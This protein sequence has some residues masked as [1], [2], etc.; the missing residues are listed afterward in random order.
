LAL[1]ELVGHHPNAIAAAHLKFFDV[2]GSHPDWPREVVVERLNDWPSA[3]LAVLGKVA[4]HVRDMGTDWSD[5]E[6]LAA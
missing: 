6:Q 4:S 5:L 3:D 1:F 2:S